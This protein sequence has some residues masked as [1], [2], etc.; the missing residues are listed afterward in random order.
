MGVKEG[1]WITVCFVMGKCGK[2]GAD[3][4]IKFDIK[5]QSPGCSMSY[6]C[7]AF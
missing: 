1:I 2:Y 6:T 3:E 7:R 4:G 5:N